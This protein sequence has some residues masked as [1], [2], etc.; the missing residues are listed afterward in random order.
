M[1]ANFCNRPIGTGRADARATAGIRVNQSI[2][3]I[4]NDD[5]SDFAAIGATLDQCRLKSAPLA[6]DQRLRCTV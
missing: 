4:T 5:E 2:G 1:V 3:R 6:P